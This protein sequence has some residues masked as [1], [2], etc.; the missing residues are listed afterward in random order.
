MKELDVEGLFWR[1]EEPE[2][3]IAGR[4]RLDPADG[5][6]LSLVEPMR[7]NATGDTR[8]PITDLLAGGPDADDAIR[9]LGVTES[10][11]LT[12]HGCSLAGCSMGSSSL[13]IPRRYRVTTVLTGV[14]LGSEEPMSFTSVSVEL[15]NLASW[16]GR[17]GFGVED[18]FADDPERPSGLR[19]T[20]EQVP[21]VETNTDDG[22]VAIRFS[23]AVQVQPLWTEPDRTRVRFRVS[24]S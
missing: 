2:R 21:A 14:H 16:V 15:S 7:F 9:F 11:V 5:A 22:S 6:T 10:Q 23:V 4:L 12:L 20:Y 3:K 1:T 24:L 8:V 18:V 13:M 19:L 17:S